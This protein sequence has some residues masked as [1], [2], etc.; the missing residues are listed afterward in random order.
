M[1]GISDTTETIHSANEQHILSIQHE[2]GTMNKLMT[3]LKHHNNR[4]C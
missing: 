4:K 1:K 2:Y 3:L